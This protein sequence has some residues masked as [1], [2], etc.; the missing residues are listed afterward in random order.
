M[1]IYNIL[2]IEIVF[3][4]IIIFLIITVLIFFYQINAIKVLVNMLDLFQQ[5][6]DPNLL[7]SSVYNPIK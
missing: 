2:K 6:T 5:F 1:F 3:K 7:N 4:I